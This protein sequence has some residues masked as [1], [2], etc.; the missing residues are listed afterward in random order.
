MFIP[1]RWKLYFRDTVNLGTSLGASTRGAR[2]NTQEQVE[3]DCAM[4]AAALYPMLETGHYRTPQ[5]RRLP[6][7]GDLTKLRFAEGITVQ[8][9]RLLADF[10]FR[11]RLVPGTQEI[12]TKIGHVCFW[13]SI[14]Y[15]NGFFMT[16]TPGERHNHLAVRLSRYRVRDPLRSIRWQ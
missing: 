4:A 14:V 13:S 15:G 12:R 5:G 16:V 10:R 1:A 2:E 8:Q 9:K 3:Q 6:I 11:T 7:D